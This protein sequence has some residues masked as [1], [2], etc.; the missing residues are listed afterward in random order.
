MAS[1][2][3]EKIIFATLSPKY[4]SVWKSALTRRSYCPLPVT[5]NS[6]CLDGNRQLK[7]FF[8]TCLFH[9]LHMQ[10]QF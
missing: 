10:L 9:W 8:K 3:I 7:G 4:C 6:S 1:L 2:H 5:G